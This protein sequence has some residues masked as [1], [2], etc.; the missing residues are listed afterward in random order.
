MYV[1][2]EIKIKIGTKVDT[3]DNYSIN[4]NVFVFSYL[5]L[6]SLIFWRLR[7]IRALLV[8]GRDWLRL[9]AGAGVDLRRF[10]IR[11]NHLL[12]ILWC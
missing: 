9:E 10:I 7:N 2:T 6:I 8:S 1:W 3:F 12:I 5:V 4:V 11:Y